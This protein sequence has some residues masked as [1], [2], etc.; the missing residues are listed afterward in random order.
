MAFEHDGQSYSKTANATLRF[1]PCDQLSFVIPA[2]DEPFNYGRKLALDFWEGDL[3]LGDGG[4]S[5]R[6]MCRAGGREYGGVNLLPLISGV[7]VTAPTDAIV[8]ATFHLFNFPDFHGTDNF[9]LKFGNPP[10]QGAVRCGRVIIK[11]DGWIVTIAANRD[12]IELVKALERVGMLL[13]TSV[14][15]STR[16]DRHLAVMSLM[17]YWDAFNTSFLSL[18]VARPDLRYQ[19]DSMLMEGGCLS[20]GECELPPAAHGM[21]RAL[22]R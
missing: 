14:A 20:N 11:A 22:V 4:A 5:V 8:S 13:L 6:A 7:T 15:L 21:A 12:T 16:T 9:V 19:W 1:L 17:I 18:S 3:R 2:N 10:L